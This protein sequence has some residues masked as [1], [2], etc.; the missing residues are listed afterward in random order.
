MN[1]REGSAPNAVRSVLVVGGGSA[2]WMAAAWMRNAF[3]Q[4]LQVELVESDDIGTVGVGE[5]T[6]PALRR[7]NQGLGFNE[8]EFVKT[9][10]ATYKLGIEFIN[11]GKLGHRYFHPFGNHGRDFDSVPMEQYWIK[12][13]LAGTAPTLDELCIANVAASRGKFGIPNKQN[14]NNRGRWDY[15]FHFDAGLYARYIRRWCEARGVVRHEGK[16]VDVVQDGETGHVRSVKLDDGRELTADLYLDCSGFRGL[17]IEG[18]MKSGFDDWSKWLPCDRALAVPTESTGDNPTPFTR[19]T[20]QEAGW[21]WRIPLQHRIGNGHVFASAFTSEERAAEVLLDTVDTKPIAEPRLLKFKA[22]QR[23]SPWIKNVVSLGLASGF[24]EPL[25]ST[26]IHLVQ[27][28]LR[29]LVAYFPTRDF[30]PL[31]IDEFNALTRQEWEDIR[32]FIIL[33]FYANQRTDTEFWKYCTTM[34]IPDNLRNKIDHFRHSGRFVT[35]ATELFKKQSWFSVFM[36][37]FIE[38]T[39][40]HPLVDSRPNVDAAGQLAATAQWVERVAERMPTHAEFIARN[41][42]APAETM[43]AAE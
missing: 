41:A 12:E 13:W 19:S 20:A 6:I 43:I 33:H 15:A 39:A 25:E 7:F 22:G 40:Y 10:Q 37:Q 35:S 36:G 23:K 29:R 9:T 3:K 30:D 5:A 4:G 18:S 17:L 32:D 16:I 24:L 31:A 28:A 11:W 21:Q 38:P 2:G 8:A 42:A 27:S 26:S 14:P 34:E 1:E